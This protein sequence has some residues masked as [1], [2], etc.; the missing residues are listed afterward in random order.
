MTAMYLQRGLALLL[1]LAAAPAVQASEQQQQSATDTSA[2]P[3][4]R[5]VNMLQA[6]EKKLQ[7]EGEREKEL[8]DKYMCYC[9]NSGSTLSGSISAAETKIPQVEAALKEAIAS[10]AQLAEDLKGHQSARDDAKLSMKKATTIRE[11]EAKEYAAEST[12]LKTNIGALTGAIGAVEKGMA[13][14]L[15][16]SN[17]KVV[18][19]L[20]IN[21]GD[22]SDF[23][24]QMLV[25]FLTNDQSQQYTPQSGQITGILK[26]LKDTMAK[27]LADTDAAESSAI[28]NYD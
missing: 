16:T 19:K 7:A 17:A 27:T 14:F 10:K 24:R 4:R 1:L 11:K 20:A 2:N 28:S 23:D 12:E 3:I 13:G 15:Q 21:A 18:A 5:V 25:S 9:K 22:I 26:E 8:Y 6:M